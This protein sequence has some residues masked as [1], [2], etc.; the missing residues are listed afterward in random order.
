MAFYATN[1]RSFAVVTLDL[2]IRFRTLSGIEI[3]FPVSSFMTV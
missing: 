2:V 3:G 1:A